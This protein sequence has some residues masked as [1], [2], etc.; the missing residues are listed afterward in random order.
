MPVYDGSRTGDLIDRLKT[1]NAEEG[2][3]IKRLSTAMQTALQTGIKDDAL[4]RKLNDEMERAHNEV[5][6]LYQEL[7]AF[8]LD[9]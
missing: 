3:A 9:K 6:R 2:A 7:Q 5:M 1:A 8:R 4:I